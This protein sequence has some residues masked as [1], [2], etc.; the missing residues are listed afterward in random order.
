M[1]KPVIAKQNKKEKV[2]KIA[3]TDLLKDN[4]LNFIGI[5]LVIK[6]ILVLPG[7]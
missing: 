1:A 6:Q 5:F 4:K 3:G 2:K 7:Y